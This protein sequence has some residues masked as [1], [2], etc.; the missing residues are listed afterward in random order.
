MC[1]GQFALL[2]GPFF[3]TQTYVRVNT[4]WVSRTDLVGAIQRKLYI[5]RPVLGCRENH[6]QE[7]VSGPVFCCV[8]CGHASWEQGSWKYFFRQ[9]AMN[10]NVAECV[11]STTRIT[12]FYELPV[13]FEGA[14]LALA[15]A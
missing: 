4:I 7:H 11:P 13:T 8:C 3:C 6:S 12:F 1:T 5:L 2:T 15:V 10:T 14:T 9:L